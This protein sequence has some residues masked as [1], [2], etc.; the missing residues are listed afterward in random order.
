MTA[1][2]RSRSTLAALKCFKYCL[3]TKPRNILK[4]QITKLI[5]VRVTIN[6]EVLVDL[7]SLEGHTYDAFSDGSVAIRWFSL[8]PRW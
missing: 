2:L 7:R 1:A 3:A 4:S 5:Q 8:L 6:E